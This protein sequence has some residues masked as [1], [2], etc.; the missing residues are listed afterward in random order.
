MNKYKLA[1]LGCGSIFSRHLTAINLNPQHYQ[2][3]GVYDC[4]SDAIKEHQLVLL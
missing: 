3:V 2:L 4:N 1:V